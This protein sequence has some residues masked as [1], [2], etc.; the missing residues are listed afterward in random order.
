MVGEGYLVENGKITT[1]VSNATIIGNGPDAMT[2]VVAVG[3]DRPFGATPLYV[4]Q[5]RP[6]RSGRRRH[7]DGQ[8][9]LH[10][11]RR[12]PAWM[13]S[14][15]I[16]LANEALSLAQ[17]R[18]SQSAEASVSIARRFHAEARENVDRP[19]RRLHGEEPLPARLLPTDVRRRSRPRIFPPKACARQ[20]CARL[21]TPT[22]LRSTTYA[23]LPEEFATNEPHLR[24]YDPRVA[25]RD[26]DEKIEEALD[27]ER[28]IRA[29]DARIVNSSGSHYTDAACGDRD[30]QLDRLCRRL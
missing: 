30:R 26:G 2:K 19:A 18:R 3:N 8:D 20:S 25:E 24:L 23:G 14:A 16:E 9:L 21:R 22:S 5:R 4:R 10:H 1:P 12:N 6:I 13:K 27:L 29:A 11:G 28:L 15:A 7:A 17:R